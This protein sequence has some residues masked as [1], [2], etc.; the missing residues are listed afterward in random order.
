MSNLRQFKSVGLAN[1]GVY[2]AAVIYYIDDVVTYSG[3]TY[4]CTVNG[5][6]NIV[7]TN[8]SYWSVLTAPGPVAVANAGTGTNPATFTLSASGNTV[9]LTRVA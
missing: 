3:T 5:T 9:T 6:T 2:S 8:T 1:R 4:V 7:P